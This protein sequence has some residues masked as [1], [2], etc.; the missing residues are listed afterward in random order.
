MPGLKR[1]APRLAL[2]VPAQLL[3][4][5]RDF[6]IHAIAC[7]GEKESRFL[8]IPATRPIVPTSPPY[9]GPR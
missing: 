1:R 2:A 3:L 8:W 4:R 9:R 7:P 5:C 6:G